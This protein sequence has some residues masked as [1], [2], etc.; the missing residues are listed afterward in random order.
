MKRLSLAL[1][2]LAAVARAHVYGVD[3]THIEG[4]NVPDEPHLGVCN[5]N[6]QAGGIC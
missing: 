6:C 5:H 1:L 2:L 3:A 4:P